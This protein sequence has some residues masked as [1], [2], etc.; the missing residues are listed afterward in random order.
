MTLR[1]ARQ[2][3]LPEVLAIL[4]EADLP[5]EGVSE[6]LGSFVVSESDGSIVGVGGLE[7]RRPHALLRSLAV[8]PAYRR[9]GLAAAMCDRLEREAAESDIRELYLLTE[10]AER[11][12]TQRN[13]AAVPRAEAPPEIASSD[14]FSNLC[15]L[16]AVLMRRTVLESSN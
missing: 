5:L 16:S 9:R 10:T 11:F 7:I 2:A 1:R 14:E 6:N 8:K 12:F 3:D 15:S 13:F 4:S